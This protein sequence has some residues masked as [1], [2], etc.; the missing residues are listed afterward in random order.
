[1]NTY[2]PNK[3]LFSP[4]YRVWRHVVFW[5][6]YTV[7]VALIWQVPGRSFGRNLFQG[8]L[9]LPIRILY[10]YPLVYWV[11]PQFLL[12]GKYIQFAFII[13]GWA[14]AGWIL[15]YLFRSFIFIP[16]LEYLQLDTI[17]K[18]R[19]ETNSFLVLTTT[20]GVTSVIVLFKHW[21]RKQQEW[22]QAEK[23]KIMSELQLLKAQVHP[24]FLFNTLNNIYSFSLENSPKTPGMIL[25][26]S[27]L[28]GYML[29]D[30]KAE[31]VLLEKEIEVMKNYI[32]LE[33]ERYGNKIDIS[34]NIEGDIKD[35]FMAPLL[36]LPFLENAFKHGTSEQL[37][38]SWLSIDISV[39]QF[40][41][42]CKIAN[43]KN[44]I[45]PVSKSGIGIQN[46]KQRL[47]FLYPNKHELK[48]SDEGVFFV[49]SLV[50]ELVNYRHEYA[51][52]PGMTSKV[53]ENVLI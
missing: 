14:F 31:E 22:M 50:I 27:S 4:E 33:K 8:L 35:R 37:E 32:D 42:R 29:Y 3:F 6:V 11:L 30:C 45:V 20:A 12:K 15:N 24:H 44:E 43:S 19:W 28:L 41:L 36:L 21:M 1:M 51:P 18:N 53:A 47:R 9:W 23:E 34:L 17:N 16:I 7:V 25:K 26:L 10:C 49:V 52:P 38:K 13:I 40:T 2:Q 5:V 46:V 39:K 48:L